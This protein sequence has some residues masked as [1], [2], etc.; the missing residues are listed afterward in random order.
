MLSIAEWHELFNYIFTM[1]FGTILA[2]L[3]IHQIATTI[4]NKKKIK[5]SHQIIRVGLKILKNVY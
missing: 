3:F 1:F 2:T 4:K 5:Q